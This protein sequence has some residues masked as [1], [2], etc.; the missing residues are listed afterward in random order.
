[1]SKF[2]EWDRVQVLCSFVDLQRRSF[3]RESVYP[4][5]QTPRFPISRIVR[6]FS[7][8]KIFYGTVRVT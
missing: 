7:V 3:V 8:G 6:V 2:F 4:V 1:M 5:Q